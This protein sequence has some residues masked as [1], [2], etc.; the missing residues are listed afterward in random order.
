MNSWVIV[1]LASICNEFYQKCITETWRLMELGYM[2]IGFSNEFRR[3]VRHYW[4]SWNVG[5]GISRGAIEI[6]FEDILKH[7][8]ELLN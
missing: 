5:L 8:E 3:Y 4:S 2:R 1:A 7:G 6:D